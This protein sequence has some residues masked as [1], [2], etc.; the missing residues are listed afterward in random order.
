MGMFGGGFTINGRPFDPRRVDTRVAL[1]SIEDWD[2]INPSTMDHPFHLH[3]NAFQVVGSDGAPDGAW[4]DVVLVPAGRRVRI[5]VPFRDY[6][7]KAMYH[8]HILDHEDLG[9]MGIIEVV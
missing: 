9:M 7:G 1:G 3:T 8:C 4:R 6:A 2:L 5:R